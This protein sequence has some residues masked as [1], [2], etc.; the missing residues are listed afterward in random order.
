MGFRRSLVR[1]QSPRHDPR[2]GVNESYTESSFSPGQRLRELLHGFLHGKMAPAGATP[3]R[4]KTT[5]RSLGAGGTFSMRKSTG[6]WYRKFND[7]WYV[8]IRGEQIPL[9]KGKS[10]KKAAE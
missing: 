2:L 7:T 4:A 3:T 6:P 9:A 8:T 5:F 10:N 1:I